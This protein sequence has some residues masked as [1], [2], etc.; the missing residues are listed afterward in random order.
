MTGR[1][2][3][4]IYEGGLVYAHVRQAKQ[5]HVSRLQEIEQF[6]SETEDQIVAAWSQLMGVPRPGS[7]R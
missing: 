4:P 2:N 1:L 6:R 3:V 5:I 7:V